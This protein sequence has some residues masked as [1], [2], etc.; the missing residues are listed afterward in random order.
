MP[1]SSCLVIHGDK[2]VA[3]PSD[4]ESKKHAEERQEERDQKGPVMSLCQ[5]LPS[6]GRDSLLGLACPSYWPGLWPG[7]PVAAEELLL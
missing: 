3:T 6:L 4:S 5:T 7:P 2:T 1:L